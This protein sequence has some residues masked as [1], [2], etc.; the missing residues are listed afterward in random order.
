MKSEGNC[1]TYS[2]KVTMVYIYSFSF[3]Y[4]YLFKRTTTPLKRVFLTFYYHNQERKNI[5]VK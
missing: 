3:C 5:S 2:L 4:T 1:N